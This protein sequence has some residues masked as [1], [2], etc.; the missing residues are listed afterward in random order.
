MAKLRPAGGRRETGRVER[1]LL[2][3]PAGVTGW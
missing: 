1:L 2:A 3:T